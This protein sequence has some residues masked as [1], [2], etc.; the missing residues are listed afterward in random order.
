MLAGLFA[1]HRDRRIIT[2]SF[3]S[4]L[5]RIQQIADAAIGAGRKVATLGLSMKKNVRLGID[6]GVITIPDSSLIDIEDI[7]RYEPGEI[8]V[9]STGSQG[10]PMSALALMAATE[11]RWL[12]LT[13]EGPVFA[14]SGL[15][16][17]HPVFGHG[18]DHG[19]EVVVA[20]D[21]LTADER[22]WS[23]PLAMHVQALVAAELADG[24]TV[25]RGI[26]VLE[27]LFVGAHAPTG[28]AGLMDPA[29]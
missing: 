23:N 15:G 11:S 17:T 25:H 10:E 2:A 22:G 18:F 19:P 7:D 8:C 3:A 6:L 14:M 26:G 28:L 13:P 24:G 21:A 12:T 9:I 4:H 27:Q 1:E 29:R 5:H 16:Y 20:H